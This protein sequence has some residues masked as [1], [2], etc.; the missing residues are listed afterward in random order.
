MLIRFKGDRDDSSYGGLSPSRHCSC[1]VIS[2]RSC[3]I[4]GGVAGAILGG[5]MG[6]GRG[7]AAG[8]IIGGATGAAIAAQGAARP[9]GYRYYHDGCYRQRPDGAWLVVAPE[10]CAPHPEPVADD[11]DGGHYGYQRGTHDGGGQCR[12][13]RQ[14]C[15]HKEE[16]GEQGMG[17]CRRYRELCR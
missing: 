13:L 5:A 14:A 1:D 4:L 7:A 3:A 10:Y 6:G 9:G 8:A 15:L 12:E 11:Y 2:G 16:L 17:N